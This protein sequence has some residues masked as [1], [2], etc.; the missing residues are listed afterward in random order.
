MAVDP[1]D[2]CALNVALYGAGGRRWTMT[3]RGRTKVQRSSTQ[4]DIGPSRVAWMGDHLRIDID[5]RGAP[6]PRRVRGTVKVY[7]A[8]LCR[9]STALDAAGHHRWGP[10]AP[11]ARVTVALSNPALQWQGEGYLDSNDGDEPV[12][13]RFLG[14]DWSRARLP[15]GS[16]AVM[17]DVRE[18]D[19]SQ[20]VIAERFMP[21]GSHQPFEPPPRQALPGTLWQIDRNTRAEAVSPGNLPARLVQ[22]LEDTPFYTRSL[23]DMRLCGQ[24]VTAVHE[25]LA[26]QRLKAWPM[27]FMLPWRMPRLA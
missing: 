15:D 14:W 20:R 8:A 23:V 9:F 13:R 5:E 21:D 6:L 24:R 2:H 17:Y 12:H 3:E 16:T 4:F 22:T 25:T 19:G 1:E 11:G 7:P 27:R 18:I 26:P 10:I